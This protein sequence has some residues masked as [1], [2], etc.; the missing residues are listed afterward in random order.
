[1]YVIFRRLGK[2][3]H[4]TT[5]QCQPP[6]G[7]D[8]LWVRTAVKRSTKVIRTFIRRTLASKRSCFTVFWAMARLLVAAL[9][10]DMTG[11]D[12]AEFGRSQTLFTFQRPPSV[13]PHA[14]R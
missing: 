14:F 13:R 9:L 1:M 10:F 2:Q 4:F 8:E 11:P 3:S 6:N 7:L 12:R 5:R